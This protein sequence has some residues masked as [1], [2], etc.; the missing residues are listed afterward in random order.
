MN[1]KQ[2]IYQTIGLMSGTSLDGIDAAIIKTDGKKVYDFGDFITIP[3]ST[4][5][6]ESIKSISLKTIEKIEKEMTLLH[7]EAVEKLLKKSNL[8][9]NNIDLIGFHGHTI[10]HDPSK[11]HTHQ[12]G[13]SNLLAK[14][15]GINVAY[16]FRK[17]DVESGGEG[18]PLVPIFL[19]SIV[20]DKL[21]NKTI[22]FLNI[23]GVA[24]ITYINN[25]NL[26]AF[27]TGTGNA[28]IDDIVFKKI[29]KPFDKNGNIAKKGT[30]NIEKLNNLLSL[31]YFS[32]TPPK[33]LDRNDFLTATEKEIKNLS[34]NDSVKLLSDFTAQSIVSS[35]KHLPTIPSDIIVTGGGRL[36]SYIMKELSASLSNINIKTG[37][38]F[39]L[40]SDALEAQAFAFLAVRTLLNLPISFPTTTGVLSPMT[41]GK[42]IN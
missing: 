17:K 35:L 18:A 38:D 29:G 27:D 16:D 7:V 37:E 2:K 9:A 19:K 11:N 34:F 33:S 14:E 13:D 23:G 25:D 40:N 28:F 41:G 20:P 3:Y 5:L 21:L 22:A 8:N 15:T 24:N 32:K 6:K 30:S 39:G 4:T 31:P 36:N 26:I 42:I 12:I 1:K 10:L